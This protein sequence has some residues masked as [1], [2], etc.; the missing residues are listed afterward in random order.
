MIQFTHVDKPLQIKNLTLRNR[1]LRPSHST[2]YAVAGITD[3]FIQFH[4]ARAR[5]GVALTILEMMAVHDT[6]PGSIPLHSTPGLGDG[7]R[8]L[9]DTIAPEGM[10]LFQQIWHGGHQTVVPGGLPTWSASDIPSPQIAGTPPI[11]MSKMMIDDVVAGFAEAARHVESWGIQGVE[12]HGAHNYLVQQFLQPATNK[13]EDEYGGSLENRARFL[14]EV[15]ESIRANVSPNFVL[16][17]S[18]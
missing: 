8:R 4:L 14:I 2:G 1:I 18:P 9:V 7:Y 11:P 17:V 10:A 3:D 12:I 16:G 6:S 5:G 15:L 13:R